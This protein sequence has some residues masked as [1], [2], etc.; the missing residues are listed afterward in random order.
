MPEPDPVSAVQSE[1]PVPVAAANYGFTEPKS[2]FFP[3][4]PEITEPEQVFFF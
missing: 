4:E 3:I 2:N 1:N